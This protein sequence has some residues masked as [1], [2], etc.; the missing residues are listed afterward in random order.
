VK[1]AIFGKI[2]IEIFYC[3]PKSAINFA[4]LLQKNHP[5]IQQRQNSCSAGILPAKFITI[6]QKL[7]FGKLVLF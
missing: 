6:N 3:F 2:D 4:L 1:T 5:M 7:M